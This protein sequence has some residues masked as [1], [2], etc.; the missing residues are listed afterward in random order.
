VPACSMVLLRPLWAAVG[1]SGGRAKFSGFGEVDGDFR[2]VTWALEQR[3]W[4]GGQVWLVEPRTV[5]RQRG[6]L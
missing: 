5:E 2:R 1:C 6:Q 3:L 4:Q